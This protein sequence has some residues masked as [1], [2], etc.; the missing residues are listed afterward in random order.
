VDAPLCLES[1]TDVASWFPERLATRRAHRA[2]R[3]ADRH[4]ARGH[5]GA[6]DGEPS[7]NL[8]PRVFLALDLPAGEAL[9]SRQAA[10]AI[11]AASPPDSVLE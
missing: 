5:A 1:A 3:I 8:A 9:G 7:F 2:V 11:R 4:N 6:D 10:S